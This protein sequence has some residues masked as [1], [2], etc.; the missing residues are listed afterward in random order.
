MIQYI[1]YYMYVYLQCTR[2]GPN[3]GTLK[4]STASLSFSI[5]AVSLGTPTYMYV[6]TSHV[7]TQIK[8]G[9]ERTRSWDGRVGTVTELT[10]LISGPPEIINGVIKYLSY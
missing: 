9:E 6:H 1:Q 7:H 2:T 5:D 10:S 8:T 3:V 4:A